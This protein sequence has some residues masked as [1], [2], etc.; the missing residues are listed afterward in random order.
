M[1]FYK[2]LTDVYITKIL[3]VNLEVTGMN[4][5]A[6]TKMFMNV[7]GIRQYLKANMSPSLPR[8]LTSFHQFK[9]PQINLH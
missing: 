4:F 7:L 5:Y 6:P 9:K 3:L 8:K 2:K 1:I